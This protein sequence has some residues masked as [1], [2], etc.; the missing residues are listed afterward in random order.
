MTL[1]QIFD[2]LAVKVDG[3]SAVEL[4][5]MFVNWSFTDTDE[6]ARLELSNGTLHSKIGPSSEN[7]DVSISSSRNVLEELI[8]TEYS[9]PQAIE[10][11][12]IE[13][14]GDIDK[15]LKLWETLTN[16]P[17]FWPIIEP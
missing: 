13:V 10:D 16:F 9:L 17:L 3:K 11:A 15:I 6:T 7:S 8:A 2:F 5:P 14:Q 4:S 12:R 1:G